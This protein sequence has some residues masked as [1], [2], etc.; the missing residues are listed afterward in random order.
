MAC[1]RKFLG[2]TS[3]ERRLLVGAWF[4]VIFVRAGLFFLP[5]RTMRAVQQAFARRVRT[6][7]NEAQAV[8]LD[9]KIAWAVNAA[10][11]RMPGHVTCLRRA[12]AAT[13]LFN[14][15]G[16]QVDML[17]GVIRGEDKAVAAHAWV[18]RSGKVVVGNLKD[19]QEYSTFPPL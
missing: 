8:G 4:L 5:F 3:L 6:E 17:L 9:E 18:E 10:C 11:V 12:I 14:L 15:C 13:V 7:G 19:L 1:L 2:L 16:V